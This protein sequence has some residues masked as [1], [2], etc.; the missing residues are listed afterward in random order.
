MSCAASGAV[1]WKRNSHTVEMSGALD[2]TRKMKISHTLPCSVSVSPSTGSAMYRHLVPPKC[3][4]ADTNNVMT[5]AMLE[6]RNPSALFQMHF[7]VEMFELKMCFKIVSILHWLVTGR[8]TLHAS[9]SQCDLLAKRRT[10]SHGFFNQSYPRPVGCAVSVTVVLFS[11]TCQW[12]LKMRMLVR[13]F[14]FSYPVNT[15]YLRKVSLYWIHF[16]YVLPPSSVV[17]L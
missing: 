17:K 10:N 14:P 8:R 2:Q 1:F 7:G 15:S 11:V 16:W 9:N 3:T 13:I 5:L 6:F 12:I 4:S